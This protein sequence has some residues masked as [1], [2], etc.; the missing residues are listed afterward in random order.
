MAV[1][2]TIRFFGGL[3]LLGPDRTI[4]HFRSQ[5]TATLLA[6][7]AYHRGR[8][9]PRE[10][11]AE[12]LWP[13]SSRAGRHSLSTALSSLRRQIELPGLP[14]TAVLVADPFCVTLSTETTSTDVS[15]F[16]AALLRA[17]RAGGPDDR[18]RALKQAVELYQGEFLPGFYDDWVLEEQLAHSERFVKALCDLTVLLEKRGENVAALEYSRRATQA[19]PLRE[20]PYQELMRLYAALG[21]PSAALH[22]Y[23]ELVRVFRQEFGEVPSAAS[24]ALAEKIEEGLAIA[25]A[26]A[27]TETEMT[28]SA[29][30]ARAP[31]PRP[32][33]I[34]PA[35]TIT[36]LLVDASPDPGHPGKP[37]RIELVLRR[38]IQSHG[39]HAG[40]THDRP[41][42]G[43]FARAA[44]A[45]GCA[46]ACQ[47]IFAEKARARTPVSALPRAAIHTGDAEP[48]DNIYGG[49]VVDHAA[50]LLAAAH[51]GQILCSEATARLLR[52]MLNGGATVRGLGVYRVGEGSIP[53]RL[54]QIDHPSMA[55]SEFPPPRAAHGHPSNLPL[56][57]PRFFGREEEL[58]LLGT[59]LTADN[60]RLVTMAGPPGV[61][62][63][64]LAFEIAARLL[65]PFGGAVWY[66]ALA[67]LRDAARIPEQILAAMAVEREQDTGPL[68]QLS[69]AL[70]DQRG[71]LVL[72]DM[73]S[74]ADAAPLV[75]SLLADCPG[76]TI[77]VT[78]RERLHLPGERELIISPLPVS[79]AGNTAAALAAVPSVQLFVDRAQALRPDFELTDENAP[80][81]ADICRRLEGFPLAIE[82]AASC[83]HTMGIR[84]ALDLFAHA[85]D[86][87]NQNRAAEVTR[88][89]TL[90]TAIDWS[91]DHLAPDV[92]RFF[93]R[94]AV[95][96]DGWTAE[97]AES[98][99]GEPM[100]LDYLADLTDC[101][102]ILTEHGPRT[103]RFR[104]L[105]LIR[106]YAWERLKDAGA[107]A[108][109]FDRHLDYYL[110]LAERAAPELES[111]AS[112]E[113]IEILGAEHE[114]L[115]AAIEHCR[116]AP[117]RIPLALRLAVAL[118]R[119]WWHRGHLG[120][121]RAMLGDLLGKPDAPLR[122]QLRAEALAAIGFLAREQGDHGA[123]QRH[124]EE[125]LFL[126]QEHE[127]TRRAAAVLHELGILFARAGDCVSARDRFA[128][129][130]PLAR[131][132]GD[133]RRE[134]LIRGDL[135]VT[136]F[137]DGQW[138][139]AKE[140]IEPALAILRALHPRARAAVASQLANL[141][142]ALRGSGQEARAEG[143]LRECLAI[144]RE[145]R[146]SRGI[147][148][149][150]AEL[151]AARIRARDYPAAGRQLE[152]CL[153]IAR[154]L[155]DR[156]VAAT[157]LAA[158]AEMEVLTGEPERA[159][160]MAGAAA[161]LREAAGA[162]RAQEEAPHE[163]LLDAARVAL[164]R[165]AFDIAVATGRTMGFEEAVACALEVLKMQ[166]PSAAAIT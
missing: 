108:A 58:E 7:L 63:S 110:E 30:D 114:N 157:V 52:P 26:P 14:A 87:P 106:E 35:G 3:L 149:T 161:A 164:G 146:D 150:L 117:G 119:F 60:R 101:S 90:R 23:R 36:F 39:G 137:D 2:W 33:R 22:Y 158:L 64:R 115:L 99:C 147:A 111:G 44:D 143:A 152:E 88:H 109:A 72:D 82:L 4:T 81:L 95:F 67:G 85:L 77:L 51:E 9:F 10:V 47:S 1:R 136:Y 57:L 129:A 154:E 100:A 128:R 103:V 46:V 89:P 28:R 15:E 116:K 41:L 37:M 140:E 107:E 65:E 75:R 96:R 32:T 155:G 31:K 142:V 145:L 56:Q 27:P 49:P 92:Q 97:A 48:H 126:H 130:L 159:A 19:D 54:Y 16:K 84:D 151:A 123:A 45:V 94:L 5:K 153:Q 144:R 148:R 62:K 29:P 53:E 134:A 98:V 55:R 71:L 156:R 141:A 138:D 78:S 42:L 139:K 11:L 121:G 79:A 61:G 68:T 74:L 66:A 162:T 163:R 118:H 91:H 40:A 127:D 38:E 25:G 102:L 6:Y 17:E 24:R 18:I 113:W 135:G 13:G 166:R 43:V 133:R 86:I 73:E 160:Q 70:A 124:L 104:M 131:E 105:E 69:R 165:P 50:G 8:T 12:M 80:T 20:E 122:S 93:A 34:A 59:L 120:L 76:L 21:E 132:A 83:I 125:S 112:P